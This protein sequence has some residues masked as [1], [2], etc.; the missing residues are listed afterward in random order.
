VAME[1]LDHPAQEEHFVAEAV[2]MY[3]EESEWRRA[4][5][6]GYKALAPFEPN[7]VRKKLEEFLEVGFAQRSAWR[8]HLTG[9]MLRHHQHN[10]TKYF[11]QWIEAKNKPS[12]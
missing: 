5:A 6:A 12:R 10:S 1:G 4:Q 11:S 3:K 2:R 9:R 8:A 7:L